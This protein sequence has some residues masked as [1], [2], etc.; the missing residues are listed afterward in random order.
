MKR[1]TYSDLYLI[2]TYKRNRIHTLPSGL[3]DSG[4]D[5]KCLKNAIN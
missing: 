2:K 4:K 1:H 5:D 3:K